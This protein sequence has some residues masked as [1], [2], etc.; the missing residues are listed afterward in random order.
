[1]C[2]TQQSSAPP[3]FLLHSRLLVSSDFVVRAHQLCLFS[4]AGRSPCTGT[5]E[6]EA[7]IFLSSPMASMFC[8]RCTPTVCGP[9]PIRIHVH[10]HIG[11]IFSHAHTS[12]NASFSVSEYLRSTAVRF[13]DA[14]ATTLHCPSWSYVRTAPSPVG[15]A[16]ATTRV[17]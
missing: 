12:A 11:E 5:L 8:C 16:S 14:Y 9:S 13:L 4:L 10:T 7:P 17:L 15:P 6:D 1:M 2:F 3:Q